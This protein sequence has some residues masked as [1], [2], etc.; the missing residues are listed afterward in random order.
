MN[1]LAY[2]DLDE[3]L[4]EQSEID[5]ARALKAALEAG[6]VAGRSIAVE[7]AQPISGPS[8][9]ALAPSIARF[10]MEVLEHFSRGRAVTLVPTGGHVTTQQAAD[11]LNVSRPFL[12]KLIDRGELSCTRVGRHRRLDTHEL[13][14]YKARRDRKQEDALAE[15]MR[16]HPD[17]ELG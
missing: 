17:D 16:L 4:P 6:V 15:I 8:Q 12:I 7:V 1:A 9:V 3:R 10:M 5:N 13:L 11:I 14:A 2:K